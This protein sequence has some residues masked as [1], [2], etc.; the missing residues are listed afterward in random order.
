MGVTRAHDH[1]ATFEMLILSKC[2]H[3]FK[4]I[5]CIVISDFGKTLHSGQLEWLNP[6]YVIT[7]CRQIAACL[8][9]FNIS[10]KFLPILKSK[11]IFEI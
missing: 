11:D 5:F 8:F 3:K 6:G 1:Y 4:E 7:P 9:L 10:I 2:F